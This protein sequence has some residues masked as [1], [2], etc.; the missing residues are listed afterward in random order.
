M[1]SGIQHPN[2]EVKIGFVLHTA[3][4]FHPFVNARAR[5]DMEREG[6]VEREREKERG[7]CSCATA[8]DHA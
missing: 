3:V 6:K 2:S 5:H 1:S 4:L 8:R 7:Y